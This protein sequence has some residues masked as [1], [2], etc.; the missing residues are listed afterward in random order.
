VDL[1]AMKPPCS[2]LEAP[3]VSLQMRHQV[4]SMSV[5]FISFS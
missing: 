4:N 2:Q 3:F 5:Y 1:F